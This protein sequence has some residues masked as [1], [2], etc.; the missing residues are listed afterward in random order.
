MGTTQQRCMLFWTDS[1]MTIRQ[2][3]KSWN[4]HPKKYFCMILVSK[5]FVRN[6]G[7]ISIQE[8]FRSVIISLTLILWLL[9]TSLIF[10]SCHTRWYFKLPF[11]S[12]DCFHGGCILDNTWT[13]GTGTWNYLDMTFWPF[14]SLRA[15]TIFNLM[16]LI[17]SL[18][19]I[20][21]IDFLMRNNIDCK[22]SRYNLQYRNN[23]L[24]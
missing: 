17:S 22:C 16:S 18:I 9:L 8:W 3:S 20:M 7:N 2:N 5:Y 23:I 15:V 1:R 14:S 10:F 4:Q 11:S 13:V 21:V 19:L 6:W 12:F 24:T